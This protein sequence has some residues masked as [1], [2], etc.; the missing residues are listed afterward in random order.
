MIEEKP[1]H[2]RQV[3]WVIDLD[4]VAEPLVPWLLDGPYASIVVDLD[5]RV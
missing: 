2:V 1:L 4:P 5:G 3:A